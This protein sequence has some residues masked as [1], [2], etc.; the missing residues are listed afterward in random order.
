M[1][2]VQPKRT[3][4][5]ELLSK[6]VKLQGKL[7][8]LNAKKKILRLRSQIELESLQRKGKKK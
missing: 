8:E 7:I 1:A 5:P 3:A 6:L 4:F 2:W